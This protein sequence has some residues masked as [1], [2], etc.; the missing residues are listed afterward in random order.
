M[1]DTKNEDM[2]KRTRDVHQTLANQRQEM[3]DPLIEQIVI[4]GG[5][6]AYKKDRWVTEHGVGKTF[7]I[8]QKMHDAIEEEMRKLGV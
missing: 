8:V 4:W 7:K 1:A 3:L 2:M 6:M 5:V